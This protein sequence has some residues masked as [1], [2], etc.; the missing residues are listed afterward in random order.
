[1]PGRKKSEWTVQLE[2]LAAELPKGFDGRAYK[3]CRTDGKWDIAKIAKVCRRK[4]AKDK[5]DAVLAY[6]THKDSKPK[7]KPRKQGKRLPRQA[8]MPVCKEQ[9][10]EDPLSK[11]IYKRLSAANI[12]K[13]IEMLRGMQ[14]K[15]NQSEIARLRA[16]RVRIDKRLQKLQGK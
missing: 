4:K 3:E 1:M 10:S 12:A 9:A 15:A 2:V 5:A 16:D 13:L 7:A 6:M 14:A 11:K 8:K